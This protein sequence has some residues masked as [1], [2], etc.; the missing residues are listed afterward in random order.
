M[1]F[2]IHEVVQLP[3]QPQANELPPCDCK[4]VQRAHVKHQPEMQGTEGVQTPQQA[5]R[6]SSDKEP[7][8]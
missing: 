6:Y 3:Y 1:E 7:E 4:L 5:T 8:A 2:E